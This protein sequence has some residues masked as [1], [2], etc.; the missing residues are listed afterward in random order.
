M[1]DHISE[2]H[3]QPAI[4]GF[5]LNPAV[6]AVIFAHLFDGCISEGIQHTV[7][8]ARAYDEKICEGGQAPNIQ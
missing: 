1:Q 6:Q 2:I 4:L 7:A 3:Q 8:G 5:A